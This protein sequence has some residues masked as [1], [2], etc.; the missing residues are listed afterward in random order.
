[1]LARSGGGA[2]AQEDFVNS[3][4]DLN[5]SSRGA[6]GLT[7][8][9]AVGCAHGGTS[10][11]ADQ[12][13]PA[14]AAALC[15]ATASTQDS[16]AWRLVSAREFTFCLPPKWRIIG[17]SASLRS[18]TLEW[19]AGEHPRKAAARASVTRSPGGGA[20][21]SN[22]DM[23]DVAGAEV[24][25]GRETIG[26]RV[27]DVWYNRFG[28]GFSTG[29]QWA[30]PHVWMTGEASSPAEAEIELAIIRTVRFATP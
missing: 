17:Q 20:P 8:L 1:M 29:G 10:P 5:N 28:S 18:A 25:R 6:V 24:K 27:A 14:P 26:G 16:T 15:S 11:Y 4:L 7:L 19:G 3:R 21:V 22:V 9:M 23:A 2:G 12:P 13:T 30:K